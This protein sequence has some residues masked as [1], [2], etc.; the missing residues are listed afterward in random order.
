[1]Q[2]RF[3]SLRSISV[4]IRS[5]LRS[6]PDDRRASRLRRSSSAVPV[7]GEVPLIGRVHAV[8]SETSSRSSIDEDAILIPQRSAYAPY[9]DGEALRRRRNTSNGS[10]SLL[11]RIL[12][13]RL[14]T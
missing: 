2:K 5:S 7:R 1:M 14:T 8:P 3:R 6:F 13:D 10:A 11:T 12:R 9:G 4:T